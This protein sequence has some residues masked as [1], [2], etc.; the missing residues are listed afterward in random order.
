VHLIRRFFSFVSAQPLTPREQQQV[1]DVLD[2]RLARVFFRQ[3]F[4]DQRHALTVQRRVGGS[5]SLAQAALL[6]DVGKTESDLGALSRSIATLWNGVGLPTT[7]AW[8]SYLDHATIGA[9]MLRDLEASDLA[10]T[11]ARFHPG[12]S[13]S[14]IDPSDWHALEDADNA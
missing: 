8:K 13:P 1:C 9:D 12:P 4:E 14:G 10:V 3:R 5:S 7:G 11:F 6:H 2:P